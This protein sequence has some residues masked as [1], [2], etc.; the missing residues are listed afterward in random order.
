MNNKIFKEEFGEHIVIVTGGNGQIGLEIVSSYLECG[1]TVVN[2]DISEPIGEWQNLSKESKGIQYFIECD[3]TNKNSVNIAVSKIIERF[4]AID[5]LIN[6]AG[7]SVFTPFEERTV[8][9]F[10]SVVNVNMRGMFLMSQCV[11][12]QMKVQKNKGVI[13]NIGSMYGHS[14]AD[15]RIY[16]ESGRNSPEVYAMTKAGVNHFTSYLGRYL[17]KDGIRV[18][19]MSPGG[20]FANQAEFFVENYNYKT[21]MGRMGDPEDLIGG[22]FYLTSSMSEY[23]TGQNLVIDG[24]FTLG[25]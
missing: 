6:S 9:E 23:V 12:E 10:D 24:G 3:I 25:G 14:V 19:C 18:N 17:A 11:I 1:A 16:G 13:L 21:P 8:E 20:I 15:Q 5:I 22:V 2:L 4:N 7:I